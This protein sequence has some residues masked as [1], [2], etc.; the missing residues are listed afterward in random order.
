V[1]TNYANISLVLCPIST[2][3]VFMSVAGIKTSSFTIDYFLRLLFFVGL[4]AVLTKEKT[5]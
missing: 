3:D 2:I 4:P 1:A 5:N